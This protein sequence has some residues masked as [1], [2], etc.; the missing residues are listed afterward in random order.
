MDTQPAS[1][2]ESDDDRPSDTQDASDS[3]STHPAIVTIYQAGVSDDG[4]SYLVMEYC[5]K[6]NLQV[7][8]RTAPIGPGVAAVGGFRSMLIGRFRS[9]W[10][11]RDR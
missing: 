7:R 5:S 2:H 1:R 8:A 10:G 6:P 3:L 4:R 11:G 9:G